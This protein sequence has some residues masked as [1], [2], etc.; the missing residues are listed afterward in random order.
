MG[1]VKG[2]IPA[3]CLPRLRREGVTLIASSK[4]N[5]NMGSDRISHENHD[6]KIQ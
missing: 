5:K 4:C 6:N 2:M 1:G 3:S